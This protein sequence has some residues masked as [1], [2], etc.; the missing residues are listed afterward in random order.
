MLTLTAVIR[1]SA[2]QEKLATGE[3]SFELPPGI[4]IPEIE[5]D[6]LADWLFEAVAAGTPELVYPEHPPAL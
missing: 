4:T 2:W 3:V 5:P 1:H 6:T